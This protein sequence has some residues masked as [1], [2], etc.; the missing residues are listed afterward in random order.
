MLVTCC[1]E[2]RFAGENLR[3]V[4]LALHLAQKVGAL[5]G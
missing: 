5:L 3:S 4:Q 2:S 1:E